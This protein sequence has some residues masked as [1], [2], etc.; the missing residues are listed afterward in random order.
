MLYEIWSE[1]ILKA[2]S[3]DLQLV[4]ILSLVIGISFFLGGMALR[5]ALVLSI[6]LLGYSLFPQALSLSFDLVFS[7]AGIARAQ[8]DH[9]DINNLW[10]YELLGYAILIK[11]VM[12]LLGKSF[13][14]FV[15]NSF[16]YLLMILTN[17]IPLRII[18]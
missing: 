1:G 18:A 16:L 9:L 13:T 8:Y 5:I 12:F 6:L 7:G 2:T 4:N 15:I 10:M 3:K 11:S 17:L 14:E